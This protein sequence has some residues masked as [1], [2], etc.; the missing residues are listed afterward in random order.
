[1]L[2]LSPLQISALPLIEAFG[3]E[4][5][6][7]IT[8]LSVAVQPLSAVTVTVYVPGVSKLLLAVVKLEPPLHV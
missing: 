7:M 5:S 1:M 6:C 3:T 4:M 2:E 8:I